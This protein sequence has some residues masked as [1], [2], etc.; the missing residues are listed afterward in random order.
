MCDPS[1][2]KISQFYS[3]LVGNQLFVFVGTSLVD[4]KL[5]GTSLVDG[6]LVGLYVGK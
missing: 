5:V 3:G 6:V 1:K 4:G 2:I